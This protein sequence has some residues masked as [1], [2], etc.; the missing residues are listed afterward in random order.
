MRL[1][2]KLFIVG[3]TFGLS[4]SLYAV[5]FGA[6]CEILKGKKWAD[7]IAGSTEFQTEMAGTESA[8]LNNKGSRKFFEKNI[9]DCGDGKYGIIL[10]YT[11]DRVGER[12]VY[13][14]FLKSQKTDEVIGLAIDNRGNEIALVPLEVAS[15][16]K[17][18]YGAKSRN[19]QIT[20]RK[21]CFRCHG[22]NPDDV[23]RSFAIKGAEEFWTK[24]KPV[25]KLA[26]ESGARA[27]VVK[28]GETGEGFVC[29]LTCHTNWKHLN[30]R[31]LTELPRGFTTEMTSKVRATQKLAEEEIIRR[32]TSPSWEIPP[33]PSYQMLRSYTNLK[34]GKKT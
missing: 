21:G 20:G 4:G 10:R 34:C 12:A 11:Q 15:D 7:I 31:P 2:N 6:I 9:P 27:E 32:C 18:L 33:S 26:E 29:S 1:V 8:V 14:T 25:E 16:K 24:S 19:P 13:E 5:N 17:G 22:P 28:G 23:S 3:I 30:P